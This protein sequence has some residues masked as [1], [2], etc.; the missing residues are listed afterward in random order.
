MVRSM[1]GIKS[2][3]DLAAWQLADEVETRV[4]EVTASRSLPTG[5]SGSQN[6]RQARLLGFKSTAN[7]TAQTA[8]GTDRRRNEP[9]ERRNEPT[10]R[11]ADQEPN[12]RTRTPNPTVNREPQIRPRATYAP[13]SPSSSSD[14]VQSSPTLESP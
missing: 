2:H 11:R 9:T 5:G 13:T 7:G 10:E 14:T 12:P 6:G 4:F 3:E 1:A 8:N